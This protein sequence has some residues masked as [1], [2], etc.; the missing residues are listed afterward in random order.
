MADTLEKI[1]FEGKVF[2]AFRKGTVSSVGGTG[3]ATG[4]SVAYSLTVNIN[5]PKE[6][7]LNAGQ[8]KCFEFYE[9]GEK[10][11]SAP[12]II[13]S[14]KIIELDV[15]GHMLTFVYK[16]NLF[17]I[18]GLLSLLIIISFNYGKV[19]QKIIKKIKKLMKK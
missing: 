11:F 5:P 1:S 15:E 14:D 10:C 8:K 16:N 2:S 12:L 6:I 7:V 9:V 19:P 18:L 13:L 3:S 4:S 17:L